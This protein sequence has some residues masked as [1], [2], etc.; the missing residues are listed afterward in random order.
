M[1]SSADSSSRQHLG[2]KTAGWIITFHVTALNSF[3]WGFPE[4]EKS[5]FFYYFFKFCSCVSVWSSSR[6]GQ[7][8]WWPDLTRQCFEVLP[9]WRKSQSG[10][11]T[12]VCRWK[13]CAAVEERPEQ[14]EQW[15]HNTLLHRRTE[16]LLHLSGAEEVRQT[17]SSCRDRGEDTHFPSP[18][19][20]WVDV[21]LC[22]SVSVTEV[23]RAVTSL[24]GFSL[25]VFFL[26]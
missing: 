11:V 24:S 18:H 10:L 2:E 22:W 7:W 16:D 15:A 21:D 12:C 26:M 20:A 3:F 6:C 1:R 23:R 13:C 5:I 4:S 25:I 17:H 8:V 19:C 14:C 9:W